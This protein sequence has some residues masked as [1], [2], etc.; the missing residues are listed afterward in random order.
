MEEFC[1]KYIL[2]DY[3]LL[4]ENKP[5]DYEILKCLALFH[6]NETNKAVN[7]A[8][9]MVKSGYAGRFISGGRGFFERVLDKYGVKV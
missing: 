7:Y 4:E 5:Y 9:N 1:A 2:D 6:K 3:I 8:L